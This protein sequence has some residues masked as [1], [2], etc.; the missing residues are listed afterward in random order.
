MKSIAVLGSG[1]AGLSAA[2]L[3]NQKHD[4]YVFE[5]QMIVIVAKNKPTARQFGIA[6]QEHKIT[7]EYLAV[8]HGAPEEK[9]FTVEAL[10]EEMI[11]FM[12]K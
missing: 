7:K 10:V 2:W 8:V 1:I 3:L 11:N 6:I 9:K 12:D 4:V 5:K